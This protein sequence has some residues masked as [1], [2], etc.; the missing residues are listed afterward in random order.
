MVFLDRARFRW[1]QGDGKGAL[2]DLEKVSILAGEESI[3]G[4]TAAG[5]RRTIKER[6]Q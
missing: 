6:E 2:T 4:K 5:L 1:I 3:I